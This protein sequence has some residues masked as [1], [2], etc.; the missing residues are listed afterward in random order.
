M[1]GSAKRT[2]SRLL[3]LGIALALL[4]SPAELDARVPRPLRP[5]TYIELAAETGGAQPPRYGISA[6]T[7]LAV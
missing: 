4:T 7:L 5:W 3:G 6:A 1:S 2:L